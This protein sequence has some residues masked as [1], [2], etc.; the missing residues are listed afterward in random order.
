VGV[1]AE[2][3]GA[4]VVT[5]GDAVAAMTIPI[6]IPSTTAIRTTTRLT[7]TT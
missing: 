4:D 6:P 2:V 3:E 5:V 1:G 7:M